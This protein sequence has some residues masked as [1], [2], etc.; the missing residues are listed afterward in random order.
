MKITVAFGWGLG[1]IGDVA[2]TP[3][4]LGTLEK[5]F[6]LAEINL[7][8]IYGKGSEDFEKFKQYTLKH[9]PK[10]KVWP[11]PF[12]GF[13]SDDEVTSWLN[14]ATITARP[15]RFLRQLF[16]DDS[17]FGAMFLTTDLLFLNSGMMLSFNRMGTPGA[18]G[19]L[20]SLWIPLII[21]RELG[22]PYVPWGQSCGPFDAPADDLAAK[23]LKD[24]LYVTTRETESLDLIRRM[25]VPEKDC[26][27][28]PDT[29][30][31][32]ATRD[33]NFAAQYMQKYELE[34]NK[35]AIFI[36][37]S[38]AWW[39]K[40]VEPERLQ[41]HM[42]FLACGIEHCVKNLGLKAVIAPECEH[43]IATA[44][45]HLMP[46]LS[47]EIAQ[48][49]V[50]VDKFWEPEEAKGLYRQAMVV[51]SMELHSIFLAVPEGT[52]VIHVYFEEMGPKTFALR[53]FDLED[54]LINIDEEKV[55]DYCDMF[56]R[57]KNNNANER[58][59]IKSGSDK[60]HKA[61]ESGMKEVK[62][63]LEKLPDQKCNPF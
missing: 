56:T 46:L 25:G 10:C 44:R 3:G 33:D 39:N 28:G 58:S 30:V 36:L 16:L 8:S 32:F 53:D 49:T 59:R 50:L 11:N 22:I 7:I 54:F 1:N 57:I 29:T 2:I 61:V 31:E 6:P 20:I 26:A 14:T 27:F 35:F 38:T 63:R 40:L 47:P 17:E 4:M 60:F 23:I 45:E 21:A 5:D 41:K 52:P 12:M 34:N 62:K 48:E 19:F 55:E 42:K 13:M 51:S 43:E 18:L 9:N 15:A 37:R 24:A